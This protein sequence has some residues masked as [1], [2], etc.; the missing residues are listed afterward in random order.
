MNLSECTKQEINMMVAKIQFP[1]SSDMVNG[2]DHSV[3]VFHE[4]VQEFDWVNDDALAFRLMVD[5]KI[6]CSYVDNDED[7]WCA[8][9]SYHAEVF[10]D[11]MVWHKNPNRAIA[12]CYILMNQE[13]AK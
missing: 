7:H 6:D 12:E 1:D 3:R 4:W 13:N 8:H 9:T 2:H 10:L 11:C 5:S